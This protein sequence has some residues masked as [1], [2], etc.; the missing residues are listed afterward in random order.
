MGS[1]SRTT[2]NSVDHMLRLVGR[3]LVVVNQASDVPEGKVCEQE[4]GGRTKGCRNEGG[5]MRLSDGR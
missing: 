2:Y 1:G 5:H 3:R 4:P